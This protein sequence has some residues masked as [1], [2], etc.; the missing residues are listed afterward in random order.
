MVERSFLPLDFILHTNRSQTC[1]FRLTTFSA[2][3]Q[4]F[5]ARGP[6]PCTAFAPGVWAAGRQS[7]ALLWELWQSPRDT[8]VGDAR[9]LPWLPALL[10]P[11]RPTAAPPRLETWLLLI[12]AVKL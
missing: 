1:L 12:S 11:A 2:S 6:A 5:A 3:L 4:G 7:L 10:Q 9:P 8:G